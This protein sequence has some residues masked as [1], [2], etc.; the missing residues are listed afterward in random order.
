MAASPSQQTHWLKLRVDLGLELHSGMDPSAG[1]GS[2]ELFSALPALLCDALV[3][4]CTHT[5]QTEE[6]GRAREELCIFLCG[7]ETTVGLLAH[8]KENAV[9]RPLH[10]LTRKVKDVFFSTIGPPLFCLDL[11]SLLSFFFFSL[12]LSSHSSFS[13][14]SLFVLSAFTQAA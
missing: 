11:L 1:T 7:S 4:A 9:E 2:G 14:A 13:S 5:Q 12:T 10:E 8:C 3:T 6:R